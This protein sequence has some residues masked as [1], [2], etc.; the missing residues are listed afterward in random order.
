M[1]TGAAGF[2]GSC[3]V[4]KLNEE[5]HRNLVLVDRFKRSDRARNLNGKGYIAKVDRDELF[6]S[7]HPQGPQLTLTVLDWDITDPRRKIATTSS[8]ESTIGA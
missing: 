3:L 4:K 1:V 5:G 2:I 7:D 6:Q 8:R